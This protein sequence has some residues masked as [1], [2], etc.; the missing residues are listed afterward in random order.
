MK[1]PGK[2][3][4]AAFVIAVA[5]VVAGCQEPV[6]PGATEVD[7]PVPHPNFSNVNET[8]LMSST[9]FP[10]W[11]L[12]S[13]TGLPQPG[14]ALVRAMNNS[15][16]VTGSETDFTFEEGRRGI[17]GYNWTPDG[18][19][20][21][22]SDLGRSFSVPTDNND[23]GDVVGVSGNV[24]DGFCEAF[25]E[26]PW[27]MRGGGQVGDMRSRFGR[28][29]VLKAI[30]ERSEITG[31][32]GCLTQSGMSRAFLSRRRSLIFLKKLL[33]ADEF[34]VAND[35]NKH[36]S[37]VGVS[38]TFA[39]VAPVRWPRGMPPVPLEKLS[40]YIDAEPV[41]VNDYGDAV[42]YGSTDHEFGFLAFLAVLFAEDG[43]MVELDPDG[44][45]SR[46]Y[47]INN[48]GQVVGEVRDPPNFERRA[49]AWT[50]D[51]STGQPA[52]HYLG[53]LADGV[54][55]VFGDFLGRADAVNDYGEVA[56]LTVGPAGDP[57]LHVVIW[58]LQMG[59]SNWGACVPAAAGVSPSLSLRANAGAVSTAAIGREF[60]RVPVP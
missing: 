38:G 10:I 5:L 34:T 29:A 39:Q 37:V 55:G 7:R 46:A 21:Q 31:N 58:Q 23:N 24:Y 40:R 53:T 52:R 9:G 1:L 27:G 30:N 15:G 48:W 14:F 36:G 54:P 2:L 8:D 25:P 60:P 3:Q 33:A 20:T 6:A 12:G 49:V 41:A 13:P 19:W 4:H 16:L 57:I 32:L 50:C 42:G 26:K 28:S 51:E 59:H 43:R 18:G 47:G 35:I 11:D 56:G 17:K 45:D 22:L 44:V